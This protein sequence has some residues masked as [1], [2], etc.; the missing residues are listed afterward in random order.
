MILAQDEEVFR[1]GISVAPITSWIHYSEDE[2]CLQKTC[3]F[4]S[5]FCVDSAFTERYMGLPN[6]TDNYRGY[7]ESDITKR[8]G[9][10]REKLFLLIHGT[11][12]DNVHYQQ[13]M[14]LIQALTAEGVLFRHQVNSNN[15]YCCFLLVY[16]IV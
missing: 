5:F 11:A 4:N 3:I 13:S 2:N 1:C 9:N 16:S 15:N 8:A 6:V 12:D 7:E 10:L 14:M